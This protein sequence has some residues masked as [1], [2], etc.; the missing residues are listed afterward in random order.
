MVRTEVL[1]AAQHHQVTHRCSPFAL[2]KKN[3]LRDGD[4]VRDHATI[5]SRTWESA[6]LVLRYSRHTSKMQNCWDHFGY[7]DFGFFK[8][9]FWISFTL[10]GIKHGSWLGQLFRDQPWFSRCPKGVSRAI[11]HL[12]FVLAIALQLAFVSFYGT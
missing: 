3:S 9:F 11:Q 8:S 2:K 10:L 1:P 4:G 6:E 12:L 5:T 7:R